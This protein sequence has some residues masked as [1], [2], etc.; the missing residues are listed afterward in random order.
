ML[1]WLV[2]AAAAPGTFNFLDRDAA[3]RAIRDPKVDVFKFS[4]HIYVSP[5]PSF[6]LVK[7]TY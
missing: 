6:E 5:A 1:Y 4:T 2:S 7:C 3:I